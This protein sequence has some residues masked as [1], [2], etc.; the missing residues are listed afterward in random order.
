MSNVAYDDQALWEE[1][2]ERQRREFD[3]LNEPYEL[4]RQRGKTKS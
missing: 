2:Y 1:D 3:K 4:K